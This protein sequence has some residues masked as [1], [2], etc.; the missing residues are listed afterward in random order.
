MKSHTL[1]KGLC[2][3]LALMLMLSLFAGCE[4]QQPD[5]EQAAQ[6]LTGK[7][8][9][10]QDDG[11]AEEDTADKTEP[12]KE[13]DVRQDSGKPQLSGK[14]TLSQK[15]QADNS[16]G[17]G[18]E[19]EE[20]SGLSAEELEQI[21]NSLDY[22]ENGF[23]VCTYSR[24]EEIDWSEV[25][26]NGAG[27]A[28]EV[29]DEMIAD[30]LEA[31]G[32]DEL[33]TDVTA[34]PED[35]IFDFA[36][37]KTGIPYSYAR[38]PIWFDWR[39]MDDGYFFNMHGDTNA[40]NIH[41][42]SGSRAGN[43]YWL[44]YTRSDWQNYI[45]SRPFVMHCVIEEGN[46]RYISNLPDDAPPPIDLLD[47]EFF[48]TKEEAAKDHMI[49]EYFTEELGDADEPTGMCWCVI[50]AKTDDVEYSFDY[51]G[52]ANDELSWDLFIPDHTLEYGILYEGES[53][54]MYINRPWYPTLRISAVKNGIYYGE[55][56]VGED[57]GLHLDWSIPRYIVGHDLQGEGRGCEPLNEAQLVNFLQDGDWCVY[58]EEGEITAVVSFRDYRSMYIWSYAGFFDVQL[59]YDRL[60]AR[61]NEA[62]DLLVMKRGWDDYADWDAL[63]EYFG[64][65]LGDYQYY[66]VQMLGEQILILNQANNGD[67]ALGYMLGTGEYGYEFVLTRFKG[68]AWM[69]PQG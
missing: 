28:I 2:V 11:K 19:E 47:I 37:E 35:A 25:L 36:W 21:N 42:T 10:T 68:T 54:A 17:A 3:L 44:H 27:I 69:E 55:Y 53:V 16:S 18:E 59:D 46:W 23:F 39:Y 15:P 56:W 22:K 51:G 64:D 58:D 8:K 65:T 30:I 31:I 62:P 6:A 50:T 14:P 57:N 33:Y 32:E 43:E 63:P 5:A 60:D 13:D 45:D 34:I 12:E 4:K 49:L 26:Y 40:Q 41:I 20:I 29:T 52:L 66:A 67:G 48:D 38:K 24:P 9:P 61:A 7:V 1:H